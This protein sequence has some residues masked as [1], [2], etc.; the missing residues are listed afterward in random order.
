MLNEL[1]HTQASGVLKNA[2]VAWVTKAR[3]AE[4]EHGSID[5]QNVNKN[6][7]SS[8]SK[9]KPSHSRNLSK[10]ST[11][12]PT[13]NDGSRSASRLSF[14]EKQGLL[15]GPRVTFLD[16][17]EVIAPP[18]LP[19]KDAKYQMLQSPSHLSPASSPSKRRHHHHHHQRRR[20]S[21]IGHEGHAVD[22]G[23]V[24]WE[25]ELHGQRV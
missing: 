23:L 13:R 17:E 7:H 22:I 4:F 1:P 6:G 12:S 14:K 11:T 16:E 2:L 25:A 8:P 9:H 15:L 3:A 10:S 21:D 18:P 5:R 19:P 20:S 24:W